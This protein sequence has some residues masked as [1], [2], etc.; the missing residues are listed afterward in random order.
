MLA[1]AKENQRLS[2]YQRKHRNEGYDSPYR[3]NRQR[4]NQNNPNEVQRDARAGGGS[5][6]PL[7]VVG[8]GSGLSPSS[9]AGK[10]QRYKVP[11]V[12]SSVNEL[13][14]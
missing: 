10:N 9:K 6:Q 8:V 5:D 13:N 3:A 7:N 1:I 14:K 4:S 12:S 11:S 2:P